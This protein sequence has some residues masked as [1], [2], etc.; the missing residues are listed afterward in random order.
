MT[1]KGKCQA[2]QLNRARVLLLADK[3]R[4]KGAKTDIEI[5]A[6]LDVSL[7]TIHRIRLK[8]VGVR[9]KVNGG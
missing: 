8:F 7:P 5:A 6:I 2:R 9:Y 3:C 4:K 1:G